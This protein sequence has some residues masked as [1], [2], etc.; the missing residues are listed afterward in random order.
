MTTTFLRSWRR[1]PSVS[2]PYQATAQDIAALNTVFSSAF[3]DRYRKDGLVG[4]HVPPLNAAVWRF[5]LEDAA[6]GAMLWRGER[7][8]VVAFNMCHLSG[9]EGWMGPLAV[10]PSY[11]GHGIG[12]R[13]V[14][15]GVEWLRN[16]GARVI[17]LETMPRTVDNIGFYSSL[18]FI[19]GPITFTLTLEA[20]FASTRIPQLSRLSTHER[21]DAVDH[22]GTMVST[23]LPGYDFRR[24]LLLTDTMVLG[25]TLL[26]ERGTSI[27]GFALCHSVPLVDG[28]G[29]EE[30]RVLK[31]AAKH[32]DDADLLITQLA[33]YARRSGTHRIAIRVQGAYTAL[34]QRLIKRGAR[35]RWTD[36]RMAVTGFAEPRPEP[37]VVLSNWEI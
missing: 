11:H 7:D 24:E 31:L 36:L 35:V 37:G 34:Y 3:T 8:E 28:R 14:S 9:T 17:G 19:P 21:M 16:Q 15:T 23:L 12:K 22:C 25:D 33:D 4:V 18:G 6:G 27:D 29:R 1:T 2:G 13:V 30:L 5:A 20:A 32:E 26:L 10:E